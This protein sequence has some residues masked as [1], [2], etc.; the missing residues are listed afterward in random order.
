MLEGE[1]EGEA[2]EAKVAVEELRGRI[3][4]VR[5]GV[6]REG[7]VGF[8][9]VDDT[10]V[11]GGDREVS[12]SETEAMVNGFSLSFSHGFFVREGGGRPR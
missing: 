9:V 1:G 6:L 4:R 5:V 12:G 3:R 10:V 11:G 2:R 7:D 8:V